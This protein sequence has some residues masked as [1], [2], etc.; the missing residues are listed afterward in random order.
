MDHEDYPVEARSD[1][2]LEHAAET[3]RHALGFGP[4]EVPTAL[5]LIN[6]LHVVRG[7]EFV[8]QSD[9][10]MGDKEAYATSAPRRIF[11]RQST[12][13]GMVRDEPRARMTLAHEAMHLELHPGA[14]KPRMAS[15]NIT[16]TFI[17]PHQSAERQARVSAAAFW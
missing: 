15:G 12:Y 10:V 9:A 11:V 7:V 8:V 4:R 14:A 17:K 13:D 6:R 2:E 16:P 5:T 3:L 1:A